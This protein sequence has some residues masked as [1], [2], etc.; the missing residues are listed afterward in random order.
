[1]TSG[2]FRHGRWLV[3]AGLVQT[4]LML[5]ACGQ[6]SG[7]RSAAPKP[8]IDYVYR[9]PAD[10]GDG[11]ATADAGEEG[12]LV[13]LLEDMIDATREEFDIVDSVA[14]AY[15]G[16]L[17]LHEVLRTALNPFDA[18]VNNTNPDMHVL[19]SAS[20]SLASL[21]VGVAI[22]EGIFSGVDQPY[23][24]LFPYGSYAN[25]DERKAQIVLEDILTMRHGLDWNE[26]DPPYSSPDNQLFSF[27]ASET[28]YAKSFLDL[29][30]AQDPG[31]QFAYS[32]VGSVSLGQAIEANAPLT[33]IDFGFLEILG[34]LGITD[35]EVLRTPTGLP[36]LGRGLYLQTRDFL[37]IGQLYAGG[38]FWN[39]ERIV[40]AAWVDA[41]LQPHVPLSWSDP[42]KFDWKITG[43][44]YQWWIGYFEHGDLQLTA[45]AAWGSGQQYLFV[46]PELELVVAVFS[47][48]FAE[49]DEQQNLVYSLVSR[50]LIPAVI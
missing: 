38:G 25:W 49:L 34:P 26:W 1:M 11:W 16:K 8:P 7:D 28:D 2:K 31:T 45:Y 48:A 29:P 13:S 23:L 18:D 36:D 14:V 47:H 9:R 6:P 4:L 33:L 19:F 21:A 41:S 27:Y 40:S 20:K 42:D 46:I 12:M 30:M 5:A 15:R 10:T 24:S 37:K 3:V 35:V 39:G 44:G 17:V 43:Y 32:T 50:Y 22:D